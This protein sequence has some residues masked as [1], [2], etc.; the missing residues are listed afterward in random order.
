MS[1]LKVSNGYP[2]PLG[3]HFLPDGRINFAVYSSD[4]TAVHL[5]L[6]YGESAIPSNEIPLHPQNNRTG[7]IWHIAIENLKLPVHYVYSLSTAPSSTPQLHYPLIDPYAR[8]VTHE[9]PFGESPPYTTDPKQSFLFHPKS[10][11]LPLS[12]FDWEGVHPPRYNPLDLVIYEMH[13]RAFTIHPSSK[14]KHPGTFL[15]VVEKIPYL[16]ELG[17]NAIELLPIYAFNENEYFHQNP[18]TGSK[19]VNFWGYSTLNFF[20]IFGGYGTH[21][22]TAVD[23]FKMMVR[24]CHRAGIEVILDV[25]YNHTAEGSGA[26]PTLSYRGLA[27]DTYYHTAMKDEYLDYTGCGNSFNCNHPIV[28]ELILDSLRYWVC[29]M[30]VDGF[31]FDLASVMTRGMNGEPLNSPPLL[32]AIAMDAVLADTKFFAEAWDAVGLYQVGSFPSYGRFAQWNDRYRDSVRKFIKGTRGEASEFATRLSGSADLFGS[33]G[34][35]GFSL[36]YVACHD[37]FSLADVVSYNEKHNEENGE[38]NR[39]GSNNNESW[40]CGAEGETDQEAIL[41]LREKQLRNFFVALLF[42]QGIPMF[43]MGDEYAHTKRGNNNTWCQDN[44][45]NWFLWDRC[46][47][48]L[49]LRTFI[50]KLIRLRKSIPLFNRGQ[51]LSGEDIHWHG[52]QP[53]TP[54]WSTESSFIAF[55]LRDPLQKDLYVGFNSGH[56]PIEIALPE[57]HLK[58]HRIADTKFAHPTDFLEV[59]HS[60]PLLEATYTLDPYSSIILMAR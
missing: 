4:A 15:G 20:S 44:D 56:E 8:C 6:F 28:R 14:V 18:I 38:Q 33:Y 13:I 7:H 26:G 49:P 19:L 24:E 25:V 41:I 29:E 16:K 40:N 59:E 47:S 42:S 54:D 17:I 57:T 58:W 12:T 10:V 22:S 37:G 60:L 32:E 31:R 2:L 30:H 35:P 23:E 9:K 27:T 53:L 52:P 5:L 1:N 34:S 36:N 21:W 51:F 43:L 39:D 50:Q 3:T 11:L 55:S 46:N 45:L 48:R